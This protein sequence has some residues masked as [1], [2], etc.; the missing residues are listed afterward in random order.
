MEK[1]TITL[2]L[3]VT[4]SEE[5]YRFYKDNPPE[6][7]EALTSSDNATLRI[8]PNFFLIPQES[9]KLTLGKEDG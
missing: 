5:T 7:H 1:Y 9:W 6:L 3:N 4:M 2:A 8:E